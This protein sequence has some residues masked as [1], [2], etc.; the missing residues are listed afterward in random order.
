[1]AKPPLAHPGG[2]EACRSWAWS[3]ILIGFPEL[4]IR[5]AKGWSRASSARA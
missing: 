2:V 1:M 4:R 3:T 5:A